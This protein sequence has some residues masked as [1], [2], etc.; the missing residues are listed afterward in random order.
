MSVQRATIMKKTTSGKTVTYIIL[1]IA[2]LS[3]FLVLD[4]SKKP[5]ITISPEEVKLDPKDPCKNIFSAMQKSLF[6]V[7]NEW[8]PKNESELSCNVGYDHFEYNGT[9]IDWETRLNIGWNVGS[10][11]FQ[12]NIDVNNSK[13]CK[14]TFFFNG[15]PERKMPYPKNLSEQL[16]FISKFLDLS[17][18][19]FDQNRTNFFS[20][21]FDGSTNLYS[22][23]KVYDDVSILEFSRNRQ[24][25]YPENEGIDITRYFRP[26]ECANPMITDR[27]VIEYS[28]NETCLKT[29]GHLTGDLYESSEVIHGRIFPQ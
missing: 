5:G 19:C 17:Y 4:A 22:F 16:Q 18:F 7:K 28:N 11:I 23:E 2:I 20:N 13:M 24:H 29:K 15:Y 6:F 10:L 25:R 27:P 26:P 9:Q 8:L 3:L 14:T 1:A 12:Y 21:D